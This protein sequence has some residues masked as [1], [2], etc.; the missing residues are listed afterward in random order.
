MTRGSLFY[1]SSTVYAHCSLLYAFKTFDRSPVRYFTVLKYAEDLFKHVPS[2]PRTPPMTIRGL[3]M[4]IKPSTPL[5]F[6]TV[7]QLEYISD[8]NYA[9]DLFQTCPILRET[10]LLTVVLLSFQ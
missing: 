9:E 4:P 5:G 7:L 8:L 1:G 2:I 3:S 6:F 10:S